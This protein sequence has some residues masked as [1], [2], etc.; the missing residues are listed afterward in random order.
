MIEAIV[1]HVES[2]VVDI[3]VEDNIE[4]LYDGPNYEPEIYN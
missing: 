2:E 3:Y 4:K 1:E